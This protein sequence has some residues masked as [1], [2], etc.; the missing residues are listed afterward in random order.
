MSQT[1]P[2]KNKESVI[3]DLFKVGAHFGMSRRRRHPSVSSYIFGFK[4][5]TAIINLEETIKSMDEAEK[6]I[7]QVASEGKK[8]LFVGNKNEAQ[9]LTRKVA[10]SIGMPYV[11]ERW[12]GGTFTNFPEIK[13]RVNRLLEIRSQEEKGELGKYT[14]KERGVIAKEK[15]DLE[16]Y[17]DGIVGME[18]LPAAIV[19]VDCDAEAI[20]VAE[21]K[22]MNVKIVALAS[23]DCNISGVDYPVIANDAQVGSINIFLKSMA[24]AYKEGKKLQAVKEATKPTETPT[25]EAPATLA[26]STN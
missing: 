14:K 8:I 23:S 12:I 5:K 16:R 13:K 3:R 4:N 15:K 6:F 2:E 26:D 17:F 1:A 7:T 10:D 21:A 11:A 18:K 22:Q 19:V 20:A 9:E 25:A 24:E